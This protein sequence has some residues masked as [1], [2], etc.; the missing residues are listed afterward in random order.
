MDV[1]CESCGETN[2]QDS[3]FCLF[4]GSFLAWDGSA[5]STKPTEPPQSPPSGTDGTPAPT[6]PEHPSESTSP[7]VSVQP[8]GAPTAQVTS[9]SDAPPPR[10][11]AEQARTAPG[12]AP[13][14]ELLCPECDRVNEPTRRFCGK[15]GYQ[16]ATVTATVAVTP[17]RTTGWSAWWRRRW[18]G[19]DRAARRAYRRSLPPIYRW[20]RVLIGVLL[21][22][23]VTVGV[24]VT[25]RKPVRWATDRW[26]DLR[27]DLVVVKPATVAIEPPEASA[28]GSVPTALTDGS[29][30]AWTMSWAP[31]G[32]GNSC[33]GAPG[34]GVVV[35]SFPPTRI[36]QITIAAGLPANNDQ[37]T[38]QARPRAIGVTFD[39]RA[40]RSFH[41]TDGDGEQKLMVDSGEPVTAVRIGVDTSFPAAADGQPLLSLT[42]VTVQSRPQ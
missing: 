4:C 21:V 19:H 27:N 30:A 24:V 31:A 29:K 17:A 18:D 26:H 39:E 28:D 42:E 32:E 33:G 10:T 40:C 38:L 7:P 25:D 22:A 15:C 35:L 11:M 34:T 20:R 6:V 16:I 13:P 2:R 9:P 36:R 3:Q 12:L 1:I 5:R 8:G 41:L 23:L 14:D 37:R